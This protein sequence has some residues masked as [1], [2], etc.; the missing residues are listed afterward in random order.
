[1]ATTQ[2]QSTALARDLFSFIEAVDTLNTPERVLD[3]LHKA[4]WDT[5]GLGVLGAFMLPIKY[6]DLD[7][8][9]LGK[10]VFLHKSV[11]KA[12]WDEEL[13]LARVSLPAPGALA[14]LAICPFTLSEA[15]QRLELLANDRWPVE[16]ALKY[17]MRDRL[18]CP[19]GGRWLVVY[20]SKSVLKLTPEQR[21]LLF[22]GA[23]FAAI[24]LQTL[25]EPSIKRIGKGA[26]LTPRELAVLRL[27]SNG[28]RLAEIATFLKLGE[29]TIRSHLKKAQA[30]LGVR[31][32]TQAVAQSLRLHLIP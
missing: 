1:V 4:S 18:L 6:G 26:A 8:L 30:K 13:E 5:C 19:V 28:K 23:S 2:S 29:E 21:A 10:T 27:L 24:R 31:D 11:P 15:M 9:E 25:A 12:W 14:Y 20:W 17:G 3:V 7:S 32:R 22:M 16:L